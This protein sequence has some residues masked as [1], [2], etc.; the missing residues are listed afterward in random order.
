V[1]IS[2]DDDNALGLTLHSPAEIGIASISGR[3]LVQFDD[4]N[5]VRKPYEIGYIEREKMRDTVRQ[6]RCND[7]GIMNLLS[8]HWIP[9]H[10]RQ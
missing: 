1:L 8:A 2:Q 9:F 6:H 10:Q 4:S 7:V 5:D 3:Q